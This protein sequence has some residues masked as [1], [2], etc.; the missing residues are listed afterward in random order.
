[1]RAVRWTARDVYFP[2]V[3]LSCCHAAADMALS[4][5]DVQDGA[6]LGIKQAVA[7]RQSL[8]KVLVDRGFGDAKMLRR[9]AHRSTGFDHV[10]S[11]FAGSFFDRVCHK[12]PSLVCATKENLCARGGEYVSLTAQRHGDTMNK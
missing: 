10:H 11:Q 6:D 8:G 9:S 1:M 12:L 3:F 2:F 7:L 4:R 5:V